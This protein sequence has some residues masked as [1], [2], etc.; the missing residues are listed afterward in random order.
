MDGIL[1]GRLSVSQ[2]LAGRL[3]IMPR[4][5][6]GPEPV[7]VEKVIT[8][9]GAY[10]ALNDNADGYSKVTANI[11]VPI[12][13]PTI[14]DLTGGYVMSG[15]W[16]PGGDTVNYSDMYAVTAERVYIIALGETVGTRFRAMFSVE[17]VSTA[18]ERVTGKQIINTSNPAA[19][20]Y[21]VHK[22]TEDG[23]ITI[24]KD[25]A[26]T[27]NLITYVFD[28]ADLIGGA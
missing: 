1:R 23:F 28:L 3:S 8:E 9:N 15:A 24:T 13:T 5:S 12:I 10:S 25:N 11:R 16:V 2:R 7:L 27:A 17:D 19:F 6:P 18:T 4:G 26:G 14:F 22:A 20:A 21:V